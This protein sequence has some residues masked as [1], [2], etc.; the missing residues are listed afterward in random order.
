MLISGHFFILDNRGI[1]KHYLPVYSP[2]S[3]LNKNTPPFLKGYL[4]E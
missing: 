4:S 3:S 2:S 1:E